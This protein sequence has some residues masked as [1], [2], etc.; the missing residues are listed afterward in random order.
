M[1]LINI[2][3]FLG[4]AMLLVVF[5]DFKNVPKTAT[6]FVKPAGEDKSGFALI[7]NSIRNLVVMGFVA[8]FLWPMVVVMELSGKKEK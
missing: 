5:W 6:R 1:Y 4:L 8:F 3:F 2:Y 7:I